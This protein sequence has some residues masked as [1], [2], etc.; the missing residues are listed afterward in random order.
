MTPSFESD[1]D[2]S[3]SVA[4]PSFLG[5]F[6]ENFITSNPPKEEPEG[7]LIHNVMNNIM[8]DTISEHIE[9]ILPDYKS[10]S[11]DE[12]I[13]FLQV[14]Y[15]FTS[16]DDGVCSEI[17]T[18]FPLLFVVCGN[19]YNLRELCNFIRRCRT[20]YTAPEYSNV[21]ENLEFTNII[22]KHLYNLYPEVEDKSWDPDTD[23]ERDMD[24]WHCL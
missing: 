18:I 24:F 16:L 22:S 3:F 2:D 7:S 1:M 8:E 6:P 23:K 12:I 14:S 15:T 9:K 20:I 21:R 5:Y 17:Y 19:T 11:R 13:S 4:A 10:L